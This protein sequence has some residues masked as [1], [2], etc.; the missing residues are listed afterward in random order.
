[1]AIAP[2]PLFLF[3]L[4]RIDQKSKLCSVPAEGHKPTMTK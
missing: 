2:E 1:M 4:K 3:P